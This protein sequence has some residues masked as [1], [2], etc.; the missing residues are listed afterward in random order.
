MKSVAEHLV[1]CLDA[2][3]PQPALEVLLP[4]AA[5]CILA[6]DVNAP[7]DLPVADL[8]SCDGYA[9]MSA[10]LVDASSTSPVFLEVLDD[11][12]AG[13]LD[14][15]RIVQGSSVHIASGAPIPSGA[16]A[17]VPIEF[18]DHGQARVSVRTTVKSGDNVRRRARDVQ[19]GQILLS[20]GTRLGARQVALLAGVGRHRVQVHPRPRV[21]VVS[22]GDELVEPGHISQP[23]KVFDANGHALSCAVSDAG[24]ATFRVAAVPDERVALRNAL[25]D[26]LVRAD[27]IITTG[28]LSY[29]AG[30]TVKEVLAPLGSVRFDNV[31][32]APGRQLG[33]GHLEDDTPIFCLPGDPVSAQVAFE[34]F[35][36]PSLRK[37]QGWGDL[38]R[39][40]VEAKV[41][42]GWTS[43]I[44]RREF[45]RVNLSGNPSEGY[46]AEVQGEPDELLLST[47]ASSN[48][49]A[50]VPE[51]VTT[52]NPGDKLVCMLL[53]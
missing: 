34:V 14:P 36:R 29:A 15:T 1:N 20:K 8:A 28:G 38:Y 18:T 41:T 7:F 49:L 32:I 22:I 21:V 23:G 2:V 10:D 46:I 50:V 37:M 17:V 25:E 42:S 5:G 47:M 11:V 35:V 4:D 19:A 9:V 40:S 39:A 53:D 33:V 52:I 44:G 13:D 3:G 30:D 51:N 27:L 45:M 26:Q 16:D 24:A 31:A 12:N 48:A 43:P 6:E